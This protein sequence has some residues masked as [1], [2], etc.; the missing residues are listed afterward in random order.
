MVSQFC[1]HQNWVLGEGYLSRAQADPCMFP[2]Q[3]VQA[4]PSKG[5]E[6]ASM[7]H[8]DYILKLSLTVL[9][10]AMARCGCVF[11]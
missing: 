8:L 2:E 6:D 3:Q 7:R 9:N 11:K 10:K 1:Q 5:L 4:V